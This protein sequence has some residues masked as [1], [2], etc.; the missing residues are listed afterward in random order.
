VKVGRVEEL[1]V[2]VGGFLIVVEA[3]EL[4]K[5]RCSSEP[6]LGEGQVVE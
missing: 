3:Q 5:S 2:L 1:M 6:V 4:R